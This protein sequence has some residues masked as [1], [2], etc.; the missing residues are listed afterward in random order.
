MNRFAQAVVKHK[1][2]IIVIF[3][4]LAIINA[5]LAADV[6]INYKMV[7]YLP[8]NSPSTIAIRIIKDEFKEGMPG[9]RVMINNVTI[10]QALEYK[11]MIKSIEGITSVSW[12][13]DVIGL[14]AL[15]TVPLEFLDTEIVE[16]YYKDNSALMTISVETGKEQD[17]VA[18]LYEIIGEE[19]AASGE[20]INLAET[21]NM[22]VDEVV[23]AMLILLP[24]VIFVLVITTTSWIEPLLFLASMG[25]AIV[26]NMGTNIIFKDISYISNTVS[27]V[28]QLAVSLDYAIFL[29]HSFNTHRQNTD[30]ETAM[31]MAIKES[32]P[33]VAAS[34]MT[35]IIGF[36]ALMFMRFRIGADL[37]ITLLKGV[38]LSF[39]SIMVFLP[40]LTLLL[41]KSLDKTRHRKLI[42]DL[43]GSGKAIMRI[44]IPFLVIALVIVIPVFLAQIRTE[45]L[46]GLSNITAS[47]R[48]GKDARLIDDKFGKENILVL[49][50]PNE[51]P[52]KENELADKVSDLP[53]VKNIVSYASSVGAPVPREFVPEEAYNQFYSE[54]YSRL[55][56]YTDNDDEDQAA[57]D[58]IEAI[59][60]IAGKYYDTYYLAGTSATLHDMKSTVSSDT[61]RI[62]ILA[63]IGIFL[64]ILLTFRSVSLPFILVFCIE[65]AIWINLS[66]PYFTDNKINFVGYLIISTVQLGATVD[67]AIL[68]TNAYLN[69]RRE[70][71][72]KEAMKKT[73]DDNL[74]AVLTSAIILASAGFALSITSTNPIVSELGILLGRGTLL[75]LVMVVL[76]LPSLLV[77]F[78]RIIQ[79]TTLNQ[80]GKGGKGM[81]KAL[82]LILCTAMLLAS[83]APYA[84]ASS[85]PKEEVVYGLLN[86]D[87]SV[88]NLYVVNI[89]QGG[90]ITDYGIYDKIIN[91]TTS[92]AIKTDGDMIT[93]STNADKFYYQGNMASKKLPWDINIKYYLD[94]V[95]LSAEDLA[96]KSGSLK[97]EIS[98]DKNPDAD[99]YFYDNFGLQVSVSLYSRLSSNISAENATIAEA[100]GSKQISFTVLPGNPFIGTVTA[101]VKDFEMDSISVNAIRMNFNIDIDNDALLGQFDGLIEGISRLDEGAGD[102]LSGI[103][104]L[105]LG[106]SEYVE[107]L[108]VFK[109]G[110]GQMTAGIDDL[111]T[112]IASL[113]TGLLELAKQNNGIN[114]G[115]KAL[116]DMAFDAINAQLQG[117]GLGLPE[118]TPEN[119]ESILS[120][121]GIQDLMVLKLQLDGIVQFVQGLKS[122]TDGVSQLSAGAG[123]LAKGAFDFKNSAGE[124]SSSANSI[125]EAAV[126]INSAVKEL[127]TGMASYKEGTGR[128]R[129][130][131]SGIGTGINEQ[132]DE[133]LSEITGGDDPLK[134]FV[135][136]KNTGISS[137]Q[138]ILKTQP[139]KLPAPESNYAAE[140]AKLT[141]W[142][143]LLKLFG[144]YKE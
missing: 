22:S 68:F 133:L 108:E 119:Y 3:A 126:K 62:N 135:S 23:N 32:V 73:I 72:K 125:Y 138:F 47:T 141:F 11:E 52:G 95:E 1:K 129:E 16:M 27:P 55:I 84:H 132:I 106:L 21:Q 35:T 67:Y 49:L 118:L 53:H 85:S 51:N 5:F 111:N 46:Y 60:S 4:V 120:G 63:V 117:M 41:Y 127:R 76:V 18:R 81:K 36:A 24:I 137:V 69:N 71:A 15:K 33:T 13:D 61:R 89:F 128:F 17:T 136:E 79:K 101:D 19:N 112:G 80:N 6:N 104:E 100:A 102:L 57:F 65:T 12:L 70:Y 29:L 94:G 114:S 96:G 93:V 30:P 31:V 144:L 7:D 37:G 97:I 20:S 123:E 8:K 110:M 124:I 121:F 91:L 56:I 116:Q 75:S 2:A 74:L 40:A 54:N 38:A 26:I 83:A 107:G 105:A 86:N 45:F 88:K 10:P 39:I 25:A 115:A 113:N 9:A 142:Q 103:D 14:D 44:R 64:V 122:Y 143:K 50:V 130:K 28:L 82:S 109:N 77:M 66:I 99:P 139:I 42:P 90:D 48:A 59:N 131:T 92:E 87:G 34:A 134:S 43:M 78:D 58:T 140:P 98:I